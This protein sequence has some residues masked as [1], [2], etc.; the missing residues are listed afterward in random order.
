MTIAEEIIDNERSMLRR[1]TK[2][3]ETVKAFTEHFTDYLTQMY[4]D[5]I[6]PEDVAELSRRL[7][8]FWREIH[9]K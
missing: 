1:Y 9:A 3:F 2:D 7:G 8:E 6:Q 4:E 5:E